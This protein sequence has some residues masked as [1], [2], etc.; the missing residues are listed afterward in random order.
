MLARLRLLISRIGAFVRPSGLDR[1]F[2]QELELHLTMLAEE[3]SRRGMTPEQARREARLQL[4]GMAPL[5]EAHRAVRGLPFLEAFLRDIQ[6]ALRALRKTPGFA[7]IAVFTLAISI[8]V[9]TAVFTVYNATVYGLLQAPEPSRLVQITR[10]PRPQDRFFSYPDYM[11]LRENNR[12]FSGLAAATTGEGFS[13]G[14]LSKPAPAL[15]SSLAD[16]AGFRFP[17]TIGRRSKEAVAYGV[18]GN[19]FQVLGVRAAMGRTILPEDDTAAAQPVALVSYDFWDERISRDP[20]ILGRDLSL[21]GINVTVVGITPRDFGGTLRRRPDLWL[22]LA[23]QARLVSDSDLLYDRDSLFCQ[24]Y[25]RLRNRISREQ[26]KAEVNALASRLQP[27]PRQKAPSHRRSQRFVLTQASPNGP[28]AANDVAGALV[29]L[30]PA[31]LVLLIACANVA[32]LLL[33]RSAARQREI[34]IRLAI[35][36]SRGR[37]IRQ[38]LTENAVVSLLAATGGIAFSWWLV[39]FLMAQI[40][41]SMLNPGIVPIH[42]APGRWVLAYSLVLALASAVGCGLA[43]A[44]EASKPNLTSALKDEGA[45][46]GGALRKS[47]LRDLMVGTQVAVCLLLLITAGML[48]RVSQKVLATDLGFDYRNIVYLRAY[49]EAGSSPA[50]IASLRAQL[51][52]QLEAMPEIQSVA[53]ARGLPLAQG[54]GT[55]AVNPNGRSLDDPGTPDSLV[56]LVTPG[57]FATMGIP[58]LRGRNFTAQESRVGFNF[59]GSPVIVSE[60][61]A[62]RLWPGQDPIGKVVAAGS[63]RDAGRPRSQVD[64]HSIASPVIGVAK[65][66]RSVNL[67]WEGD[68][69][70][71]YFPES[72]AA[73]GTIVMKTRGDE[74][75]AMAAIQR[76]FQA[77]HNDWEAEIGDSRTAFTSEGEF[78][79]A[80]AAGI[81]SAILGVL[82]LLMATVGIYGTVAFAVT[83]RTQEIGI[84][85]AM[86]AQRKSVVGLVLWETMRP[87]AIGLAIGFAGAAVASRL[88][89][90][91]LF[92]LSALDPA[93][94]LGVTTFLAAIALVAG[95]VPARRATKVDPMIALRYE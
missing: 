12:T 71:L 81:G 83:R 5:R 23:L 42:A 14:G 7:A 88:M 38:L 33:A 75:K 36:A 64:P 10:S 50:K 74:T 28:P 86:G 93:A 4:G 26:A 39:H 70:L 49:F 77:A 78:A 51:A 35:G 73:L 19:Y 37:L 32:S 57:Y 21:N 61:A 44:L 30:A 76:E 54:F 8:G 6:Y 90:A 20:H 72:A 16:A 79:G 65:D 3:Y 82:G 24:V 34:A 62:K 94:F 87:V 55:V 1:D 45:A 69:R 40:A 41:A 84:R 29:M 22:P 48:T 52:Q 9:N 46:F 2:D 31:G 92:G 11:Y 63:P 85:M 68:T 17:Q 56:N 91:F 13:L 25:G 59:D 15:H 60:A 95:Y 53:G 43:P 18:T 89:S 80:R 58:I 47:R 27:S 67:H 66:V